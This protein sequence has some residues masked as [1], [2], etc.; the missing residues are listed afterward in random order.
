MQMLF[1]AFIIAILMLSLLLLS[2]YVSRMREIPTEVW[3]EEPITVI[4][5]AGHGGED[6]GTSGQNGILEKDLNLD[7]AKKLDSLLR[8]AG[9]NTVMTRNDDRLL[10][11]P[12]SDYKGRKKILDMHER[13][14]I[15]NSCENAVFLSVHM[16]SFPQ[17]KYCGLQVYYS[18][19]SIDSMRFAESVQGTVSKYLQ[20]Q[21]ERKIKQ[22][23]DIFLLDRLKMPAILVECGFLSNKDECS[24]LSTEEYRDKLA[25]WIFY[26]IMCEIN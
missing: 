9:I 22:G 20:P 2:G 5:D 19:N 12:L 17:E 13:L 23:K 25:F 16:N 24:L 26:S 11:D 18:R 3:S 1:I 8:S 4:I 21:N 14:R 7:V 6:G 15:A 10:Y